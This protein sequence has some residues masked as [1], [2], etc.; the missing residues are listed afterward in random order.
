MVEKIIINFLRTLTKNTPV[1]INQ[2]PKYE[3]N[4]RYIVNYLRIHFREQVSLATIAKQVHLTP[5]YIG[6]IFRH[7]TGVSFTN[8]VQRLRLNYATN[9]LVSSD[10]SVADISEQSGFHSV[11]YF[12][13]IFRRINGKTPLE[14][15]NT[16]SSKKL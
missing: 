8:Y 6:N 15:R 1:I 16:T 11:S 2:A 10:L 5:N 12:I 14:Y 3:S 7:E 13:R 4:V 9:L